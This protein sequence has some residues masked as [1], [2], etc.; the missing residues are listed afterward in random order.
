MEELE[1]KL[2]RQRNE[3]FFY[4]PGIKEVMEKNLKPTMDFELTF[5]D[6]NVQVVSTFGIPNPFVRNERLAEHMKM[7]IN[8]SLHN[9]H[10]VVSARMLLRHKRRIR[11]MVA[12]M[13]GGK[14]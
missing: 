1:K 9:G 3:L 11:N 12:R 7:C 13:R 6:G 8:L 14:L 4:H 5:E 10:Y 2:E